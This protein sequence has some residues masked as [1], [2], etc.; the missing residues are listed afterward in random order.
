MARS[1][2]LSAFI[3]LCLTVYFGG[4]VECKENTLLRRA[5]PSGQIINTAKAQPVDQ[6]NIIDQCAPK[7]A[8]CDP[9]SVYRSYDGSCNNLKHPSWGMANTG[10][11]RLM[12]A[13][14]ADGK[15][16]HRVSKVDNATELPSARLLRTLLFKEKSATDLHTRSFLT[17]AQ[18]IAHDV[19]SNPES[20]G[21]KCCSPSGDAMI[22][23][24]PAVCRAIPVP[25]N[26]S[27]YGPFK[28][29]CMEYRQSLPLKCPLNDK[30]L[31]PIMLNTHYI[32]GSVIYGSSEAKAK[33]LRS[34]QGGKLLLVEKDNNTFLPPFQDLP[35]ATSKSECPLNPSSCYTSGDP[36]VNQNLDLYATTLALNKFHNYL[37]EKLALVK[38]GATDE[39]LYQTG[40]KIMGAV[41]QHITYNDMLP[42]LLGKE[43]VAAVGLAPEPSGYSKVYN[44]DV[45]P[46]TLA[47]MVA[48]AYRSL[49]TYIPDKIDFV[50]EDRKGVL[51]DSDQP[52][53]TNKFFDNDVPNVLNHK[54]G[55]DLAS[56]DIQRGRDFGLNPYNDYRELC[57]FPRAATFEDFKDNISP[58]RIAILKSVYKSVD[59]VDFYTGA[60]SENFLP[61]T[62]TTPTFRCILAEGFSRYKRADRFFYL[63]GGQPGSLTLDQINVV[64]TIS[65]AHIYCGASNGIVA[66]QPDIFH[67][68]SP[69]N[70]LTPCAD[71][72]KQIDLT[73]FK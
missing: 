68:V 13:N 24:Q 26:D 49:H 45:N 71:L 54:F 66:L 36:R 41:L 44:P 53:I 57:G 17:F 32:D 27:Y 7:V 62:L 30:T 4:K 23:P 35:V 58:E 61:G 67:P 29:V 16:K 18:I 72:L 6:Q 43:Y 69:T 56:R 48:G 2:I 31:Q 39:V 73:S 47:D 50:T 1:R 11:V 20:P 42:A 19:T 9:M 21:P 63:N 25:A 55:D 64:K 3:L 34:N 52:R 5:L 33:S 70:K 8:G 38:P 14:Y 65:L 46:T 51:V 28:R 15:S 40:R 10:H 12:A 59:D 37:V 22:E 60:F